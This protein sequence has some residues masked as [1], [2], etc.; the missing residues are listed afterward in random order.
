MKNRLLTL[1]FSIPLLF[2]IGC[3]DP[4]DRH[5]EIHKE[6]LETTFYTAVELYDLESFETAAALFNSLAE[7]GYPEAQYNL[8]LMHRNG[9]GFPQDYKEALKWYQ[10]SAEQG[11]PTAQLGLG[12][13]Y[14]YGHGV[15]QDNIYAHMWYNISAS[16]G[17]DRGAINRDVVVERMTKDQ[18][19][20]AQR[21]ARECVK[22]NYMD[23]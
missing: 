14:D 17:N 11:F 16:N 13:M 19:A 2:C 15:P 8:G 9:Q 1:I 23:C 21:L 18:L 10:K 22:K 5:K 3:S 6:I 20:E 7:D 12:F 4:K